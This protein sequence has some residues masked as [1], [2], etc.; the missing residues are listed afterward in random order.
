[1]FLIMSAAYVTQELR[2]EFGALPPSFLP[3]GNRRLFQH[4]VLLAPKGSQVFL[5]L[6]ES[7]QVSDFDIRW[8]EENHVSIIKIPDELSLGA[9]LV[10]ALNLI[11]QGLESPLHVL[12][13]DTLIDPIPYG[14][15]LVAV[16]TVEDNYDWAIVTEDD[17]EWLISSQNALAAEEHSVVTGYFRF[18]NP[19]QL[20][21]CI[22][23]CNWQLLNGLG[24]YRKAVGLSTVKV[25]NWLDFGHVNTFYRSKS[26]FTTQRVFNDL[27]IKPDWIEKSSMQSIKIEAEARWFEKLPT[28]VRRYTPQYLGRPVGKSS[29][30]YRL[31]YLHHT[32][33][34]ELYVFAD[35]PPMLWKKIL[36]EC[37]SFLSECTNYLNPDKSRPATRLTEM[38]TDKTKARLRE[39]R[40]ESST[41]LDTVFH[42]SHIVGTEVRALDLSLND[43]VAGSEANLP[44]RDFGSTLIHG[45]FCFSNVLYDFRTSRVKVIDPRGL[46]PSGE[47]SI[48]GDIRYDIAKISHSVLGMYDWIIAGRH[49]TR[50]ENQEIT[51][52]LPETPRQHDIQLVFLEMIEAQFSIK[53]V[54]LYAM[55]VQLFLSMLPLHSD[56]QYRQ[57]GFLA[58]AFRLYD[59]MERHKR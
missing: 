5:S 52:I 17:D 14:V 59:L 51:I 42:Y 44:S 22:T 31:E 37:L 19:R 39:F 38:F 12:F 18:S 40:N 50:F 36:R 11:E 20:I 58:N 7:F 57:S 45:D 2:S 41:Q 15:D 6:P 43:L 26:E 9:S 3:L 34:N 23:Q 54:E 56:D 10:T 25:S 29:G 21:R 47:K 27:I 8:L 32:P 35:I 46:T 53:P 55:Q 28:M 16:A 24:S 49:E 13:G 48:Y 30:A 1:M 4:Q 33:L